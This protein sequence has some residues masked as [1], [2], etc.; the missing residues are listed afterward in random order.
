MPNF[1][2]SVGGSGS[3]STG[4]RICHPLL[5]KKKALGAYVI[6]FVGMSGQGLSLLSWA[7][8]RFR[9]KEP[10][11]FETRIFELANLFRHESISND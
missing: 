3:H 4:V 10:K 11:A 9:K 8:L 7:C 5:K 6:K 1:D 2:L